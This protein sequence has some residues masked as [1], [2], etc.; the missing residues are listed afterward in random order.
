MVEIETLD[1]RL[2]H[3]VLSSSKRTA[4]FFVEQRQAIID[5]LPARIERVIAIMPTEHARLLMML[6]EAVGKDLG[7]PGFSRPPQDYTAPPDR[8]KKR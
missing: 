1:P 4:E 6:H 2:T 3:Q 8:E 5:Q 7:A